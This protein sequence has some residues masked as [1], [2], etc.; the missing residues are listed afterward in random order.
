MLRLLLEIKMYK[1]K[2]LED[3]LPHKGE[4]ILI[5]NIVAVDLEKRTLTS[6]ILINKNSIFFDKET[7]EV[8]IWIGI[9]YMAQSIGAFSG[10]YAQGQSEAAKIGFVIGARNYECFA[11]GFAD[12]ECFEIEVK[13]LFFDSNLG[14]FECIISNKKKIIAKAI[15]NVFQPDSVDGFIKNELN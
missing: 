8:P 3:I 7:N 4:I 12:K 2:D 1:K 11:T 5:D 9:E 14:S 6:N 15:L 10:I 13:E